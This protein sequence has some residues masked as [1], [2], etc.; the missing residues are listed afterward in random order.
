M[1]TTPCLL[2]LLLLPSLLAV[3]VSHPGHEVGT[4]AAAEGAGGGGGTDTSILIKGG[5]VVNAHRAEEAD[6]Y[7]EDGIVLAVAVRPNIG[8]FKCKSLGALAM[9]HAENGDAVAEGQQ[10][11]IDLGITGPEG[12]SLQLEGEATARAIRLAKFINTPLYVV[13]VMSIDAM[14]EITKAKKEGPGNWIILWIGHGRKSSVNLWFLG[15]YL[16]IL[17]FGIL[18]SPI[19]FKVCNESPPI[20]EAGHG[21]ALQAALSS[22]IL[23]FS[24][25]YL[26]PGLE[27]RMHIVWDSMVETGKISVTDY[28]RVTS[29]ECAKIFNIYPRKGAILEGSDAD[30]IILNPQRSFIMGAHTHHSKSD[31]NVYEGRKGKVGSYMKAGNGGSHDLKGRVVWEDGVLNIAPGSGRYVRMPPFGYIFDGIDKS[32]ARLQSFAP[33]TCTTW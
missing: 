16:T 28:V 29:T 8:A 7:I 12:P 18:T 2:V 32:D 1:A 31:T 20:R 23:Q 10:R 9:V 26:N 27:E 17:C 4:P 6:V 30:I 3:A 14:E 22:G 5:T 21:K 33:S 15:L 11:M 13:H 25:E 24:L 19:G